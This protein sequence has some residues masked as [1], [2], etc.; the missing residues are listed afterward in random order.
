[1]LRW[2]GECLA[3]ILSKPV[4]GASPLSTSDPA[5]LARA[6]RPA[7]ILL[8][9]GNSRIAVAIKYLTQSTWSHAALYVGPNSGI[10]EPDGEPHV[11][12]EADVQH[13][14]ISTPMS[15]YSGTH[16][17]ICRPVGLSP[18]ETA[19]VI[20][21]A[22]ARIG[23]AYDLRNFFDLVR[24]F[25]PTPPAPIRFRRR[26]LAFGSGDP[27]RAI[28]STL[29]AEAFQS[30]NYPILPSVEVVE[31][32]ADR[33]GNGEAGEVR[34]EEILHIRDSKL[35]APRD[36]DISPYFQVVKPT[37]ESGFDFHTVAWAAEKSPARA[38]KP[39]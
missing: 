11:F 2:L 39:V 25:L 37:I 29:I 30:I 10:S 33:S 13:G 17:R 21:F 8:I 27:T 34:R 15:K 35:F 20:D 5:A 1:M 16:S 32:A 4:K 24:Y 9:E 7:D 38:S 23:H 12:I 6:L 14:V 22:T 28:C 19:R 26:M 31:N 36:F 3:R 18:E